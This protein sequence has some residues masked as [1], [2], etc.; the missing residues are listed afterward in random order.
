MEDAL[1]RLDNLTNGL[2]QMAAAEVQR[3]AHAIDESVGRVREEAPTVDDRVAG[4]DDEVVGVTHGVLRLT[5]YCAQ[6]SL[7]FDT[8]KGFEGGT[9][10][11]RW[12]LP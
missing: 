12:R 9:R 11:W 10:G 4:V 5:A 6:W 2:A 1:Q 3:A 7:M 8:D